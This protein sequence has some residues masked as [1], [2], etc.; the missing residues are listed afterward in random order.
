VAVLADTSPGEA[1]AAT[2]ADAMPEARETLVFAV[3]GSSGVIQTVHDIPGL[4]NVLRISAAL[5]QNAAGSP[6]L[7][8]KGEV[9]AMALWPAKGP[10]TGSFA[11]TGEALQ[12]VAGGKPKTLTEWNAAIPKNAPADAEADYREGLNL[13]LQDKYEEALAFFQRAIRKNPRHA[14][15][16]FHAGFVEGKL[17][18][19]KEKIAAY[20][21]ALRIKPDSAIVHY[22]LGV[23]YALA[24]QGAPAMAELAALR[25]IDPGLADKLETLMNYVI[26]PEHEPAVPPPPARPKASLPAAS[27][28]RM[29]SVSKTQPPQAPPLTS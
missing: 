17:G 13:V 4:G 1:L 10:E 20:R 26:H 29:A 9:V 6:L 8:A 12:A 14:E 23:T 24:G 16:W 25:E 11:A 27:T 3:N 15:A 5:P 19:A 7:N 21:E 18:M 28:F 22:S 2:V